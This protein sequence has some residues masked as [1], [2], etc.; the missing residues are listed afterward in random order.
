MV[1]AL[2]M[3]MEAILSD[4]K[5]FDFIKYS[6]DLAQ[7]YKILKDY[8]MVFKNCL[9]YIKAFEWETKFLIGQL[10]NRFFLFRRS[11]E[12]ILRALH[13]VAVFFLCV[14]RVSRG[15]ECCFVRPL[16]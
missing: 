2:K 12:Q 13:S 7:I 11:W 15:T 6:F 14:F 9:P 1:N 16:E 8:N 4:N 10:I 3:S 5:L